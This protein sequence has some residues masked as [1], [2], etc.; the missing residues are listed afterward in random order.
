[1]TP[2]IL[3]VEDDENDVFFLI[4]AFEKTG[5]ENPLRV[6]RDGQQAIDY[7]EGHGPF[8]DRAAH[9]FPGLILLDLKLPRI[10]GLDVLRRVRQLPRQ[11]LVV[12][13]LSSSRNENDIAEAYRLGTNGYLSKPSNF[14]ELLDLVRAIDAFWLRHNLTA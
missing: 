9:P 5:V 10:R 14:D 6:A 3:L 11:N 8:A 7:L 13:I 12:V 1:M 2:A 4:K